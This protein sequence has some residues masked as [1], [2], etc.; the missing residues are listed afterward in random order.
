MG[1]SVADTI[2]TGRYDATHLAGVAVGTALLWPV[3]TLINGT[4]RAL[5]PIVAQMH[6]GGRHAEI[7]EIVRQAVWLTVAL[8]GMAIVVLAFAEEIFLGFGIETAVA[9][10]GGAYLDWIA[11]GFVAS[12]TYVMLLNTSNA[13]G[14][15]RVAMAIAGIAF[16]IKLVLSYGFIYG[17]LGLPEHGGP[18]AAMA[19]AIASWLQLGMMAIVT[20]RDWFLETGFYARWSAPSGAALRRLLALGIPIGALRSLESGFFAAISISLAQIGAWAVAAHQIATNISGLLFMAAL[21]LGNAASV[22]VGHHVGAGRLEHAR[23]AAHAVLLIAVLYSAA[24]AMLL[25]PLR[26]TWV[27]LYTTDPIV[28]DLAGNLLWFVLAYLFVDNVQAVALGALRGFKDTRVPVFIALGGFWLVGFPTAW[29]FGSGQFGFPD[30]GPYGYWLGLCVALTC[31]AAVATVR[32]LRLA[33]DHDR[34][35]RLSTR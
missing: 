30:L 35:K 5:T 1:N 4:L 31:V 34:I 33:A 26:E 9:A 19:S 10:I 21:A 6:G 25:A 2:M 23:V 27:G 22:A 29:L 3:V 15:T 11:V 24:A 13:L 12:A 28:A 8:A 17:N 7:G 14:H 32:L 20:R 16:F 18:G